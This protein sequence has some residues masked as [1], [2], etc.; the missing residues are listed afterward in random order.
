VDGCLIKAFPWPDV[1]PP[2]GAAMLFSCSSAL[3]LKQQSVLLPSGTLE[4]HY[5]ISPVFTH[6]NNFTKFHQLYII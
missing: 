5:A 2:S 4:C 6:N 3:V 1:T